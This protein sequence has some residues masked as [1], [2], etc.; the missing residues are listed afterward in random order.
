MLHV[1][2]SPVLPYWF[3]DGKNEK[4]LWLIFTFK[5][6]LWQKQN[7]N[8]K[9]FFRLSGAVAAVRKNLYHTYS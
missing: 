4:N 1:S 2:Y 5:F 8:D 3:S 9:K 7:L 6:F